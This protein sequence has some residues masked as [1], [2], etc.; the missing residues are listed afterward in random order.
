MLFGP[1]GHVSI[2]INTKGGCSI[3]QKFVRNSFSAQKDLLYIHSRNLHSLVITIA[4]TSTLQMME[5]LCRIKFQRP[6]LQENA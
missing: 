6:L 1:F 3:V 5:I 4:T 2:H